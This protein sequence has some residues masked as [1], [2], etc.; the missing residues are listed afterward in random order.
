M[1]LQWTEEDVCHPDQLDWEGDL[2]EEL[3]DAVVVTIEFDT[4]RESVTHD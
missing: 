3:D 1:A 2:K 4:Y